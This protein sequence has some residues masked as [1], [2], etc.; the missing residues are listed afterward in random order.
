MINI[1]V[2]AETNR[3]CEIYDPSI[4]T[5]SILPLVI[6]REYTLQ[7]LNQNVDFNCR[8][9][10]KSCPKTSHLVNIHDSC[11]ET[12]MNT[13]AFLCLSIGVVTIDASGKLPE[14]F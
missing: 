2:T 5:L 6:Y 1:S 8:N 12:E 11:E 3:K 14:L 10:L 13:V 7:S 4:L 9:F